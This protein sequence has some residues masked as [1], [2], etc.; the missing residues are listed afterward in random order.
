MNETIRQ[1][2]EENNRVRYSEEEQRTIEKVLIRIRE[3]IQEEELR[4]RIREKEK[5]RSEIF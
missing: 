2:I 1:F 5:L 3:D 4:E